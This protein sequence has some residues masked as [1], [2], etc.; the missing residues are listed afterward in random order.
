MG[1]ARPGPSPNRAATEAGGGLQ[2]RARRT[3]GPHVRRGR[4]RDRGASAAAPPPAGRGRLCGGGG[5]A[6]WTR[7]GLGWRWE[8]EGRPRSAAAPQGGDEAGPRTPSTNAKGNF[9]LGGAGCGSGAA[10]R[11]GRRGAAR[12][13][14]GRRG[15]SQPAAVAG[16]GGVCRGVSAGRSRQALVGGPA[17]AA[18]AA[19]GGAAR[20]KRRL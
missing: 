10:R 3:P 14:E 15:A 1:T 2:T 17:E 4:E 13:G 6:A 12:G 16:W 11:A 5:G 8:V 20:P 7:P 19:G 18:G 9:A